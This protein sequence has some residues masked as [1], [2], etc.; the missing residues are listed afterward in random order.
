MRL[1]LVA[2][3]CASLSAQETVRMNQI[4]FIG[5]HNSYHA[6]LAPGEMAVLRKQ[7]PQ[8]AESLAYKHP[9]L[10]AQLDAGVRQLELDIYGD[11]K[12][13]LFADPLYLR[14]SAR[15]GPVQKMPDGWAAEMK[16]PGL[17]VLHASDVDFRSHC[18]TLIGCLQQVRA[19]SK[20]HPRH[21][22]IYIQI[23]T[24]TARPRPGFVQTEEWT[25]AALDGIDKEI[26]SVFPAGEVVT[27]DDVRGAHQTLAE[28]VLKQGWPTLDRARGKVVFVF[29]QESVTPLYL[30]DH[31]ALRGRMVFTNAKPGA[32]DAAFVKVNNPTAP[33]I[34]G[35]VRKGYLV[36]TMADGGVQAVRSGD[37]RRRDAAIA[38]GAQILSTDYP[39]DWKAEGSGYRVSLG[40]E[41]VRCNPVNAPRSCVVPEPY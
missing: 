25:K 2:A 24:K 11:S 21:L 37:T 32:P 29:D 36:R 34:P 10:E 1:L 30:E 3:V 20:T 33:E 19:W 15:E 6:G 28:A 8:N 5:T 40:A 38:S 35:L 4:Q 18:F 31:P 13:G 12:G 39:F 22:P 27:P 16:K 14:L 17:K 23:E 26:R 7:N 9:S 41:K